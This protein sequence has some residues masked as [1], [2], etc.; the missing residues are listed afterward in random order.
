MKRLLLLSIATAL[1]VGQLSA[2]VR[3]TS[4][5]VRLAGQATV[6]IETFDD[7]GE[8]LGYGSGFIIRDDGVIVTSAH[9]IETAS[10]A[11][12][13]LPNGETFD[14]VDA[15]DID[16]A[17]DV[18]VIKISG[19]KLAVLRP[20][21]ELPA[22]GEKVVVIGA[23]R[24]LSQT[25][26][27]G[28]VSG[29]RIRDGIE[30]MQLT[31]AISPGSS[32]GPVLDA[33]GAVV[34]VTTAYRT[35][36]QAL[37]FAVPVRYAMGLLAAAPTPR[38]LAA[39]T[40]ARRTPEAQVATAAAAE[41]QLRLPAPGTSAKASWLVNAYPVNGRTHA[42][43]KS[44][45][46]ETYAHHGFLF[47]AAENSGLFFHVFE[48]L[49]DPMQQVYGVE[50]V[51]SAFATPDGRV[52]VTVRNDASY[53]GW[54]SD[55]GGLAL[56]ARQPWPTGAAPGVME[57]YDTLVA[58][59]PV[60]PALHEPSGLYAVNWKS[61]VRLKKKASRAVWTGMAAAAVSNDS[62]WFSISVSRPESEARIY[63]FAGP[64]TAGNFLLQNDDGTSLAGSLAN[65]QFAATL[66]DE[67][68]KDV[69]MEGRLTGQRR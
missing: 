49:H 22:V 65:G 59:G 62:I 51:T 40:G 48:N 56:I 58:A 35:D 68:V 45:D 3:S 69:R 54:F 23:P 67:S 5:I 7:R 13:T 44:G 26:S 20:R 21:A 17:R 42:T 29:V 36:G 57:R 18:A 66:V 14:H 4:A 24:H 28:I 11:K 37:N 6:E 25:V 63:T 64:I 55:S 39:L 9:V 16:A 38:P 47:I 43:F 30:M 34:A 50:F 46:P 53:N 2:Q 52:S 1:S 41:D 12:V 31:A 10:Q 19:F 32:G 33:T 61:D 8:P 60:P 27:E 15:L